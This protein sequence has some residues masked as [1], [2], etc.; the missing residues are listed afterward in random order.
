MAA[1]VGSSR[2]SPKVIVPRQSLETWRPVRP[3][4]G[5]APCEHRSSCALFSESDFRPRAGNTRILAT[6]GTWTRGR[7]ADVGANSCGR[8]AVGAPGTGQG[9]R[10]AGPCKRPSCATQWI[11]WTSILDVHGILLLPDEGGW[12]H[13]HSEDADRN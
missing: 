10:Q 8:E 13:G 3:V 5:T 11:S 2:C 4:L 12:L 7:P 6:V 1:A 9:T